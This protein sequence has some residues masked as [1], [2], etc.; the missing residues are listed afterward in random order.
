MGE[1]EKYY[2]NEEKARDYTEYFDTFV[3]HWCI[4]Y[5]RYSFKITHF[6]PLVAY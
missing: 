2:T 3:F 5:T 1:K 6:Y 4:K